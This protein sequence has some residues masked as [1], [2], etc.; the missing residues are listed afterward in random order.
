MA[1]IREPRR[2]PP[3]RLAQAAKPTRSFYLI[4]GLAVGVFIGYLN[5]QIRVPALLREHADA[6]YT[7]LPALHLTWLIPPTRAPVWVEQ[8]LRA[9]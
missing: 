4:L 7:Y 5:W 3:T 8:V 9:L 6:A 1:Q 2:R